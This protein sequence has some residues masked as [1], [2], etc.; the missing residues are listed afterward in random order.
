[1]KTLLK[2]TVI[3]MSL[4]LLM[5]GGLT[6]CAKT[7]NG[8]EVVVLPKGHKQMNAAEHE[9]MHPGGHN[10]SLGKRC[11]YDPETDK[12]YCNFPEGE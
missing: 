4:A 9:K 3:A 2:G 8:S 12:F 1:M 7:E 5:T 11:V 6:G 10:R